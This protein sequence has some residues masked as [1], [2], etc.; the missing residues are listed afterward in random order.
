MPIIQVELSDDQYARYLAAVRKSRG[1]EGEVPP[2][3]LTAPLLR[4]ISAVVY[5]AEVT[6]GDVRAKN[7]SF[8]PKDLQTPEQ[9]AQEVA[10]EVRKETE[11]QLER[12]LEEDKLSTANEVR[13]KK[14]SLV[15]PE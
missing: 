12:M 13:A 14:P 9:A 10:A 6:E 5:W 11:R 8:V 2:Q 1:L 15:W 7:W 4:E 3:E